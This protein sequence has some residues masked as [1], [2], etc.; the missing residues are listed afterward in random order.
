MC[1][2]VVTLIR[3]TSC[4]LVFHKPTNSSLAFLLKYLVRLSPT[5]KVSFFDDGSQ[6]TM[7]SKAS[8][9]KSTNRLHKKHQV[10]VYSN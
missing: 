6:V 1:L 10:K 4:F 5:L 7:H 2:G 3:V 9:K 8:R